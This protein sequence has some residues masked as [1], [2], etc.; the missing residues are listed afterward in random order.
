MR[1]GQARCTLGAKAVDNGGLCYGAME[2]ALRP[3][4]PTATQALAELQ[5]QPWLDQRL[6]AKH[7][8]RDPR[9][10]TPSGRHQIGIP[11][12]FKSESVAGF[13][14]ECVAGFV[15]IR[16]GT[17]SSAI[18]SSRPPFSTGCSIT[19]SSSRSRDPA[20]AYASTQAFSLTSL[21]PNPSPPPRQS[22]RRLSA[23]GSQQ[24]TVAPIQ[25]MA[26]RQ[27]PNWGIS[28]RHF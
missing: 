4:L 7:H 2:S 22:H 3:P 12:G 16:N 1:G 17:K 27:P 18:P 9:K 23:E 19:P 26:D 5:I 21:A 15:G 20:I 13:L 28:R 24:K 10:Q 25:I 6:R 8:R 14:L 11:A